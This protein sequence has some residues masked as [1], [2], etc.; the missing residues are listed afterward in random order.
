[1]LILCNIFIYFLTIV[2][3]HL[4][5]FDFYEGDLNCFMSNK[6][7]KLGKKLRQNG[8]ISTISFLTHLKSFLEKMHKKM[9]SE[10]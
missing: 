6:K 3:E 1:M 10:R 5:N 8:D 7:K 9:P 4:Y 2:I